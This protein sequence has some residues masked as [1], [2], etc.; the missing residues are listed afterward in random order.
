MLIYLVV[1]AVLGVFILLLRFSLTRDSIISTAIVLMYVLLFLILIGNVTINFCVFRVP[2][3][4]AEV[5]LWGQ[6]FLCKYVFIADKDGKFV[7][8]T[9]RYIYYLLIIICT[10]ITAYYHISFSIL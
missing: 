4:W 8:I 3:I 7:S 2:V 6:F 5:L 9:N 10:C 1:G